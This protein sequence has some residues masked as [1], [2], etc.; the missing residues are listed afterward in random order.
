M[1]R[2]RAKGSQVGWGGWVAPSPCRPNK[3]QRPQETCTVT[4]CFAPPSGLLVR[5]CVTHSSLTTAP[6]SQLS[7]I[8]P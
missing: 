5:A 3:Q 8:L 1:R 6:K 7:E 2:P 4:R